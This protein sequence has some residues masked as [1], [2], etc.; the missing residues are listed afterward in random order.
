MSRLLNRE[1]IR[2]IRIDLFASQ[3]LDAG[4]IEGVR[5]LILSVRDWFRTVDDYTVDKHE[6]TIDVPELSDEG[7]SECERDYAVTVTVDVQADSP[8]EA[9]KEF[10]KELQIGDTGGLTYHVSN[11][12]TGA[13]EEIAA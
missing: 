12:K 8:R 9:A 6:L 5:N 11:L 10:V 4:D 7:V 2:L 3:L 13:R 1:T